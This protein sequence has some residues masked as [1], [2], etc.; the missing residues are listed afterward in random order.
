MQPGGAEQCSPAM[1]KLPDSLSSGSPDLSR[2][3]LPRGGPRRPGEEIYMATNVAERRCPHCGRTLDSSEPRRL[4]QL[5]PAA[6]NLA[7]LVWDI[8]RQLNP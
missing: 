7:R 5:A 1:W 6:I 8:C 2:G 3:P 4:W